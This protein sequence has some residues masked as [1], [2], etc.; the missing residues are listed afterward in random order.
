MK[1]VFMLLV[2]SIV[3]CSSWAKKTTHSI[4]R[5]PFTKEEAINVIFENN[6]TTKGAKKFTLTIIEPSGNK[7]TETISMTDDSRR[8]TLSLIV[9]SK[10]YVTNSVALNTLTG[11]KTPEKDAPLMTVMLRDKNQS[12]HLVEEV[13]AKEADVLANA[14]KSAAKLKLPATAVISILVNG[15]TA[16]VTYKDTNEKILAE[17]DCDKKNGNVKNISDLRKK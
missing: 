4:H 3:V 1:K 5:Q 11:G 14:A 10:V 16:T 17:F 13:N 2:L 8:K 15:N 9:G 6:S 12:I 7:R